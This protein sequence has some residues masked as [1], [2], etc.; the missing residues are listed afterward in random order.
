[1]IFTS[2]MP[3]PHELKDYWACLAEHGREFTWHLPA[4]KPLCEFTERKLVPNFEFDRAGIGGNGLRKITGKS[5][6][7]VKDN[8]FALLSG[9]AVADEQGLAGHDRCL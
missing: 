4:G 9:D 1:M 2:L 8:V 3:I 5:G 6:S 7:P